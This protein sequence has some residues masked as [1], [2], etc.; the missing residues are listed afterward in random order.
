LLTR[1]DCLRRL[2]Q[3]AVDYEDTVL[4]PISSRRILHRMISNLHLIYK[5]RRDRAE[6]ARLEKFLGV[7]G[8]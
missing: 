8:R 7:I 4:Q 1:I 2:K 6:V 5:E 3:F